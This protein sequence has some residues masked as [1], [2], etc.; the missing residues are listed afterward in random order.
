MRSLNHI[1]LHV[2][3]YPMLR[4]KK[5]SQL[6]I[7][8]LVKEISHVPQIV[9]HRSLIADEPHPRTLQEMLMIITKQ[10]LNA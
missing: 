2:A 5:R 10:S 9:I 7:L 3:A 6:E 4:A 8:P 1:I